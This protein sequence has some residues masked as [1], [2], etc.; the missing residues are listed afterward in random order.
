MRVTFVTNNNLHY[1]IYPRERKDRNGS[2]LS[3]YSL[4]SLP[5]YGPLRPALR[6]SCSN[7]PHSRVSRAGSSIPAGLLCCAHV[8]SEPCQS[9]HG[10]V[11]SQ[12]WYAWS[13]SPGIFSPQ[14][15]SSHCPHTFR[16]WVLLCL[17]WRAAHRKGTGYYRL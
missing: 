9:P 12:Q 14:L 10:A 11:P 8:L 2:D 6:V 15:P 3:K 4:P 13:C 1:Y 7:T 16:S 5:R 17:D